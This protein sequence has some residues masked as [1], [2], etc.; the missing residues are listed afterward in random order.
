MT[1]KAS[2]PDRLRHELRE[3]AIVAVYLY[4]CFAVLL[5]YKDALL[6]EQ[7]PSYLHLGFAA[8]KALILGKFMLI[9]EAAGIGSRFRA[10][11][12]LTHIARKIAL[13]LVLLIILTVIEELIV[14][15]I[16]GRTVG[17]VA[18][19]FERRSLLE[20]TATC[21]YMLL[22]LTPYIAV[23]ELGRALGPGTLRAALFAPPP[24]AAAAAQHEP[25]LR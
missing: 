10:R 8:G 19:D 18:E 4:V 23:R 1:N 25:D 21:L 6:R 2:L 7:G 16:H 9:G 15:L 11:N 12:L 17:E 5:L 13:F 24:H 20:L 3:Y 22:V 14:G